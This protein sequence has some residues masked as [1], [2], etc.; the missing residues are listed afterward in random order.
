MLA[1]NSHWDQGADTDWIINAKDRNEGLGCFQA[2]I[3]SSEWNGFCLAGRKA[4]KWRLHLKSERPQAK[5]RQPS[6][7]TASSGT[8]CR[9]I[10]AVVCFVDADNAEVMWELWTTLYIENSG[11]YEPYLWLHGID[12]LRHTGTIQRIVKISIISPFKSY[13]LEKYIFSATFQKPSTHSTL[14]RSVYIPHR[15]F[16]VYHDKN[17]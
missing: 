5:D 1:S 15:Q 11:Q 8:L 13:I 9:M 10:A 3:R 4:K 17:I 2:W 14:P 16:W 6:K 12:F 7:L